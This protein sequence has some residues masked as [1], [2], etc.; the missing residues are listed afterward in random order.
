ML[1]NNFRLPVFGSMVLKLNITS[2]GK[3]GLLLADFNNIH[4]NYF[5]NG[6]QV[7]CCLISISHIYNI[8]SHLKKFYLEAN[9]NECNL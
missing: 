5:K 1:P 2:R 6:Y 7:L 9:F 3:K 4:K 8:I